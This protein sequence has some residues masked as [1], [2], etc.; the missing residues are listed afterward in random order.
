MGTC[1]ALPRLKSV[2]L[3][4]RVPLFG[5]APRLASFRVRGGDDCCRRTFFIMVRRSSV[6]VARR[7]NR[8]VS[9]RLSTSLPVPGTAAFQKSPSSVVIV[10]AKTLY[11]PS[12]H[13]C[14]LPSPLQSTSLPPPPLSPSV[15]I[16]SSPVDRETSKTVES[17][18][19]HLGREFRDLSWLSSISSSLTDLDLLQ[20]R[21]AVALFS[22]TLIIQ[23]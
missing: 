16:Q 10:V 13:F 7:D 18:D 20:F 12:F 6:N 22:Q 23:R 9:R 17:L 4:K 2:R 15:L 21:S 8:S 14:Q 11:V 5:L 19:R 3:V 1:S